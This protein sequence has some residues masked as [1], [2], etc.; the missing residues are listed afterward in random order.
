MILRMFAPVGFARETFFHAEKT[1][2]R[3]AKL[4][5][6]ERSAAAALRRDVVT[7]SQ[8]EFKLS[9]RSTVLAPIKVG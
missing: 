1:I 2:E 9:V 7:F 6:Q 3:V 5:N 8:D 4:H